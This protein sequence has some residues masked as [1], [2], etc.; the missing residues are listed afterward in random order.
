MEARLKILSLNFC[1]RRVQIGFSDI[2]EILAGAMHLNLYVLVCSFD[3]SVALCFS[4]ICRIRTG[5]LRFPG[6]TSSK[7]RLLL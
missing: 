6:H 2:M 4:G 7:L 5:F 3:R 1:E